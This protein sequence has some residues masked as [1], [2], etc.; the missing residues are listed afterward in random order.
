M[1]SHSVYI[2]YVNSSKSLPTWMV[3]KPYIGVA[4]FYCYKLLIAPEHKTQSRKLE[5]QNTDK[6][7]LFWNTM[8]AFTN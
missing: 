1:R 2:S 5:Q 3:G 8:G 4:H 6:D 7:D